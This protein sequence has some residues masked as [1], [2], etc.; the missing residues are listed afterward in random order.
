MVFYSKE[1]LQ[2]TV[3]MLISVN[4]LGVPLTCPSEL[5]R[6]GETGLPADGVKGKEPTEQDDFF[7]GAPSGSQGSQAHLAALS[8][9]QLPGE[10]SWQGLSESHSQADRRGGEETSLR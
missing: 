9:R 2:K 8:S 4:P 3:Q 6:L 7:Q 10:G 5:M 1:K